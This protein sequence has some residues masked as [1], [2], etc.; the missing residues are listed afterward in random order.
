MSRA[1]GTL[2]HIPATTKDKECF[3]GEIDLNAVAS[4]PLFLDPATKRS[5][6]SPDYRINIHYRGEWED[7]GAAWWKEDSSGGKFLSMAVDHPDM[8]GSVNVAA[9]FVDDEDQPD[10]KSP[11]HMRIVWERYNP[12]K[13]RRAPSDADSSGGFAYPR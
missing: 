2:V 6:R 8:N 13:R 4:G 12:N 10:A 1:I 3:R 9:F 7:F 11:D 5:D